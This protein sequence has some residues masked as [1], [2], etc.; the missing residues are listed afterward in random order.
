M[1]GKVG[2]QFT[3]SG[4]IGSPVLGEPASGLLTNLTGTLTSPTFVTPALGTPASGTLTDADLTFSGINATR[5][6]SG[7]FVYPSA[8]LGCSGG[9]WTQMNMNLE[10]F[11]LAGEYVVGA[12]TT[13]GRGRWTTVT[14]GYYEIKAQCTFVSMPDGKKMMV[15]IRQNNTNIGY[16]RNHSGL[17]ENISVATFTHVNLAV[18]DYIEA[19]AFNG[20]GSSNR[21]HTSGNNGTTFM[22]ITRL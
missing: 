9:G 5:L 18:D 14:A 3:N 8:N 22:S 13:T 11:D 10:R 17:A 7:C 15:A 4:V 2:T 1:S 16:G 21:D 12:G 6:A 19:W 20:D